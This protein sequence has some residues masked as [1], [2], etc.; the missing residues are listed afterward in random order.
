MVSLR[1]QGEIRKEFERK[2]H[3][4]GHTNK[5]FRDLEKDD[6]IIGTLGQSV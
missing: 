3:I 5:S 4:P 1:I 6:K 2:S